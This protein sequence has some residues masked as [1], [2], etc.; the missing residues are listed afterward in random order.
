[1]G[2]GPSGI[3]SGEEAPTGCRRRS[4]VPQLVTA[5][6]EATPA[7]TALYAGSA[8]LSYGELIASANQLTRYLMS[9]GIGPEI[10]VGIC[11]DRSFDRIVA[12]LAVLK[13]GGAFLPLDPG[14][15]DAR[16]RMLLADAGAPVLIGNGA[17]ADRLGRASRRVEGPIVVALDSEAAEIARLDAGAVGVPVR[18]EHLAYVIY[19]SGSTGKPKGVEITHGNLLNL[20]FWHRRAFGVT[21]ADKASH[22]AGLGFDASVWEIWPYLT[23]GA[24]VALADRDVAT[25]SDSL[26]QWL[27]D[28]QITMA[29]VPT[30]LAEPM[31]VADWPLNTALR[32]LL[33]GADTLHTW[34]RPGLPFAVVNNYGPTECTVVATSGVIP[35]DGTVGALPP[36][37][38]PIAHTQIHLLGMQGQ[39]VAAGELGEIHIGGA[40]IGRGYR[41]RPDLTAQ[42]FVPDRFSQAPGARLYRT[43]DL[44]RLLPDGQI[45]FHGRLDNQVKIRGH[46]VEPDEISSVLVQHP[47]VAA[48]A[49]MAGRSASGE[50]RLVA[51]VV[52]TPCASLARE[53]L[54][55]FLATH[56]PDWMIPASFVRLASLPLTS[57]G[58]LDH[59]ALPEPSPDNALDDTHYRAPETP[60][61]QRM[62][63]IV[64]EVLGIDRVGRDDNFFLMGGHS[65]LG[66]Q[67]VLRMRDAFAVDV[68]LWH[69]FEAKTVGHLA[70]TIEQLLVDKVTTMT[71]EEAQHQLAS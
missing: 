24:S 2:P 62:A 49:V 52:P 47:G 20:V 68:T 11:L 29:F 57:N 59:T 21:A 23:A 33:T 36:I 6:A 43:G 16:L 65:L 64:A 53:A 63:A 37:G 18:R 28:E 13:A 25:S 50:T 15:P 56:L 8:R 22:L 31:M 46:R 4:C 17:I 19:T 30:A 40:S 9:L 66:A 69:L 61:E 3:A 58:K 27:C 55:E 71:D 10:P 32:C 48:G 60:M 26:R 5:I 45:A 12:T 70:V 51:Y 34:P 54:R 14:W 44:G 39:P 42:A 67:V 1:M 7:A 41:N 35:P 38:R